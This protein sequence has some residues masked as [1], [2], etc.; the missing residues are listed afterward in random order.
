M[1]VRAHPHQYHF[2]QRPAW[3][4]RLR[5]IERFQFA[6][7]TACGL[8]RTSAVGWDRVDIGSGRAA[9]EK[10]LPRHSHVIQDI[11]CRHKTLIADEPVHA[12]PWDLVS[13]R[14]RREQLIQFLRARAPCQA[15]RHATPSTRKPGKNPD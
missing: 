15:N 14:I 3:I 5:A 6:L 1:A 4:E 8:L 2:E 13:P 10:G 12:L 11:V 7:I 9:I